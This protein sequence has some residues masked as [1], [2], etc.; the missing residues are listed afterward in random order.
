[1][2]FVETGAGEIRGVGEAS[3]LMRRWRNL[4][5]YHVT[6]ELN[7]RGRDA[8]LS[9]GCGEGALGRTCTMGVCTPT[10]VT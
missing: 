8:G 7:P 6:P 4:S 2:R 1:V 10:L 9:A 5:I 3:R